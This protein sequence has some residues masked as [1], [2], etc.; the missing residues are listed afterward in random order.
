MINENCLFSHCARRQAVPVRRNGP[1]ENVATGYPATGT[2][3]LPKASVPSGSPAGIGGSGVA[4]G[5]GVPEVYRA[6][7]WVRNMIESED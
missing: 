4:S 2:G 7:R 3:Q 1:P 6:D 5:V